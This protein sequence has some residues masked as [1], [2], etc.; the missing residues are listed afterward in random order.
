MP[1]TP[2]LDLLMT[3]D[4]I[5]TVTNQAL[6]QAIA[7]SLAILATRAVRDYCGWRVA[8]P[9]DETFTITGTGRPRL[10]IP[11]L[12]INSVD[13]II[14]G[15]GTDPL[16][17]DDDYDWDYHG[18]IDRHRARWTRQRRGITITI[19]HGHDEC[20]GGIAQALAAAVARGTLAPAAGVTAETTLSA[21]V[22]YSR[23][24]S[25]AA[26]G[27]IFLPHELAMLD[28]HRIPQTR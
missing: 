8:K 3:P 15:R 23:A 14:D 20:P 16:T 26:A 24:Q 17:A 25:G 21:S 12:M 6:P 18:V 1:E 13:E 28:A 7:T 11:S 19:N 10:F 22:Q 9:A 5:Q 27:S 2:D 4:E